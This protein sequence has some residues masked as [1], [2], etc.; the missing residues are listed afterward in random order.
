[1]TWLWTVA[2]AV[3]IPGLAYGKSLNLPTRIQDMPPGTQLAQQLAQLPLEER[4]ARLTQQVL[5]GNIPDFLRVL[6]PVQVK[7][8]AD[9]K[10]N[11]LIFFASADY[12]A[13]GS[14]KDY[15]RMPLTPQTAQ[16]IADTLGCVLPT[17]KMVDLIYAAAPTKLAP[18]PIPPSPQMTTVP[19]FTNHN[20]TI[21]DQLAQIPVSTATQGLVAG[22]K[23][24]V[25]ITPR[26][27]QAPGKVAIYGWHQT[28]GLP[29]QPL[30]LGHGERW[31]DYSQ[32][33]RL[34][35]RQV[36]L[37]GRDSDIAAVLTNES[38]C[39]LLS[40][41][42]VFRE[43]R[44]STNHLAQP[45]SESGTADGAKIRPLVKPAWKVDE[46]WQERVAE[47]SLGDGV[48]IHLSAPL[49]PAPAPGQTAE[50]IVFALPNGN[51]IEQTLGKQ[52]PS[53]I[54]PASATNS[55]SAT[56]EAY[57]WRF[58][59]QHIA[60]QTRFL[61]SHLPDRWIAV[62]CIGN[63]LKS[64]PAWRKKFGDA[65]ALSVL[66]HVKG[67]LTNSPVALTLSSHSGGGS[68]VFG[69]LN[70]V[71][72]IPSDWVRFAFLDSNYAYD[73]SLGHAEKLARWMN[74]G[75][76][77]FLCIM[78]Y[79]D[80]AALLDGKS[81]VSASGGTWG[82]SL[83]MQEDLGGYW[84]FATRVTPEFRYFTALQGRV[85]FI[86]KENPERKI[87]H[88]VQVERNGFIHSFLSGTTN[89][90]RGYEYFGP[91]AYSALIAE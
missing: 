87:Y 58:D 36:L 2:L 71:P 32:C 60:A 43:I 19:V 88:T 73:R 22:H 30:Y 55:S 40:D 38:L 39:E 80:A 4:E 83:A 51:T 77:R 54:A 85:Q 59:I 41:E 66:N 89:E 57:D 23:K 3:G 69:C 20:A 50:L 86:L 65:R 44:Y 27:K 48:Q 25:V 26:L 18:V 9:G 70:A 29:I 68:F 91:R 35:S 76:N 75:T 28:N 46:K 33:I 56:G 17:R 10:T 74:A 84:Q 8:I 52:R 13:V 31:V 16:H 67:M 37:N 45:P 24:D 64:W 62:A 79:N 42:G 72:E 82:R 47:A 14:A 1:M 78:A 7:A 5:S 63:D 49:K 6:F 12:L 21:S 15:L 11:E 81:F 61:R 90:N 34:I 53:A